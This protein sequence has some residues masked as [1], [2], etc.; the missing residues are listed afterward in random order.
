[1][2]S[3]CLYERQEHEAIERRRLSHT[4]PLLRTP[5]GERGLPTALRDVVVASTSAG[6][7]VL[8]VLFAFAAPSPELTASVGPVVPRPGTNAV[9]E[10]RV[11]EA[12]G[13]GLEGARI[14]VSRAGRTAGMAVS[15]EGGAFRVELDG[16]C[17]VY[18]VS[19]RAESEGDEVETASTRRLCP[20]DSLPVDARVVTNGHFL[21]VPGP[22]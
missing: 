6:V 17:A 14:H 22:R 1:M 5:E 13:G 3:F 9:V 2:T 18:A 4:P 20:G 10:G 21:W 15:D 11:L 8:L 16:S 19:V 7:V 12:N